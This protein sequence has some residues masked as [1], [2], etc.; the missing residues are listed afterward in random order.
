[1]IIFCCFSDGLSSGL[2][3]GGW[4]G[5]RTWLGEEAKEKQRRKKRE[6]ETEKKRGGGRFFLRRGFPGTNPIF[7]IVPVC[8]FLYFV[9]RYY[10]LFHIRPYC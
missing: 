4:D 10:C 3:S 2:L 8:Y 9:S 1:M 7:T 6:G 5:I